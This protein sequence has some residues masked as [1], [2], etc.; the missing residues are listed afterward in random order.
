MEE[1]ICTLDLLPE[2]SDEKFIP[3]RQLAYPPKA[4]L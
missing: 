2:F 3:N 4:V 1:T